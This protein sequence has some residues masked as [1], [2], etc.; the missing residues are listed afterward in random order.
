MSDKET[1]DYSLSIQKMFF[2]DI[3]RNADMALRVARVLAEGLWGINDLAEQEPLTV[4]PDGDCWRVLGARKPEG[5]EGHGPIVIVLRK[6]DCQV[7]SIRR[8]YFYAPAPEV[9]DILAKAKAAKDNESP[10]R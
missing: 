6:A 10:P 7:V 1:D 8:T 3:V 2:G 5:E 4:Q 9:R